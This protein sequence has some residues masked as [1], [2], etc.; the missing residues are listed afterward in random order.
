MARPKEL[1]GQDSGYRWV[2][3]GLWSLSGVAGF[4]V[5]SSLGI[6]LPAISSEFHLSPGQQG[7]LGSAAFWGSFALAI[8]L[9]WWTSRYGPKALTS[10]TLVLGTLFLF[11]QGWAPVFSV[12]LIG[13]LAFGIAMLAREPARALLILQWFPQRE[14]I[15]ANSVSNVLYGLVVAGGLVVIPIILTSLGDNWRTTTYILGA[16]FMLVTILLGGAG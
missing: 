6:L 10:V 12:L 1:L 15:L 9:S 11:L 2:V 4:M 14:I 16:F 5:V 13:R 8:P 7:L 3:F